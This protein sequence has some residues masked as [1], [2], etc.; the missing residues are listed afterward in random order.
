MKIKAKGASKKNFKMNF[1]K[2]LFS[3]RDKESQKIYVIKSCGGL[4]FTEQI[5]S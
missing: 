4:A 2:T 5:T 1:K 3:E